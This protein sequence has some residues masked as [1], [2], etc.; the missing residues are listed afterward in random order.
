[1]APP[2]SLDPRVVRVQALLT[3][4]EAADVQSWAEQSG[5]TVSDVIRDALFASRRPRVVDVSDRVG[6]ASSAAR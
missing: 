6:L 4:A 1:M 5:A 3:R 2:K